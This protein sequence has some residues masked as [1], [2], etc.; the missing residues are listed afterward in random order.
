MPC[1]S[2][3]LGAMDAVAVLALVHY[4]DERADHSEAVTERAAMKIAALVGAFSSEPV[5]PLSEMGLRVHRGVVRHVPEEVLAQACALVIKQQTQ[6]QVRAVA[7]LC[8][9]KRVAEIE[10]LDTLALTR[11]ER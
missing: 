8:K 11:A 2:L 10:Q 7:A 9:G 6:E 5:K 1:N 3:E 4:I